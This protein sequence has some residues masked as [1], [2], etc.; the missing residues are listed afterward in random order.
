MV[1]SIE[2]KTLPIDQRALAIARRPVGLKTKMG[3]LS[4]LLRHYDSLQILRRGSN[5]LVRK[6]QPKK[7]VG[8]VASEGGQ[9]KENSLANS[10]ADC[11]VEMLAAHPSHQQCDL[12]IG[13]FS[14]LNDLVSIPDG[15]DPNVLNQKS[16]L[17]R[18]QFHYHE[19]LLTLAANEKWDDINSFLKN[20]LVHYS[21]EKVKCSDDAWHPY[22]ISRRL[23]AW[24]WL[25]RQSHSDLSLSDPSL[26]DRSDLD[27]DLLRQILDSSVQQAN[28]LSQN[29]ERDLGGN[30]LLENV[31]ALAIASGTIDSVHAKQWSEIAASVLTV[32]LPRQILLHGEHFELSPMYHCQILSNLLR[33]E[34]CCQQNQALL[35]IVSPMIDPM[36]N[37]L[38]TVL[39]PDEEIPLFGDSGF[40]EAPSVQE[41][42]AVARLTHRSLDLPAAKSDLLSLGG[43][44][45]FRSDSMFGI[46]DFG[47]IAAPKLP[48]HG[49]CDA[50][51]LEVSIE[52]KRWIVDSGNFNYDDDAMRHYSRS[53]IGHNVVTVNDEN[54]ANVWSKFRMGDR[55]RIFGHQ[56]GVRDQ[57]H[58]ATVSHDG[59]QKVGVPKLSRLVA[60]QDRSAFCFDQAVSSKSDSSNLVG[61]LHFH[62]EITITRE[63][64]MPDEIIRFR[65]SHGSTVRNLVVCADR[66]STEQGWYCSGFG[67]REVATVIRYTRAVSGL[68]LGWMLHDFTDPPQI[69]CSS[70][71]IQISMGDLNVSWT[72]LTK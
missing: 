32:E 49:H 10:V 26:G 63:P 52:G 58:W 41:L 51:N 48:A 11:V 9:L 35:D 6:F 53:S 50:T 59:Y 42:T 2:H 15:Y 66:V 12:S 72:E 19:F 43:Y 17:W 71:S 24:A 16:H 31:T 29:L 56:Q 45:I 3:R 65:L 60:F 37:F 54:Q 57:W 55:P 39:H 4:Q 46:C 38:S 13:Q 69:Q 44:R 47:S 25:M 61:Y 27:S 20:W 33:I 64:D 22:C 23:V 1:N 21:P 14:M 18:F 40:Y 7:R 34:A 5:L 62:P 28:F 67:R 70:E 8:K 68:I 36:L 30:H